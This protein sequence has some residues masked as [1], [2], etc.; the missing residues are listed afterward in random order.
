MAVP[1]R[2]VVVTPKKRFRIGVARTTTITIASITTTT[3]P[4][5]TT[6]IQIMEPQ[7]CDRD[8]VLVTL[9]FIQKIQKKNLKSSNNKHTLKPPAERER[10]EVPGES[11]QDGLYKGGPDKKIVSS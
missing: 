4:S 10:Q 3:S 9:K 8:L 7:Q 6:F 1:L 5:P 2:I 11:E